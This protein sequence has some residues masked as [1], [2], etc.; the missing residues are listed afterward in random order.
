VAV[1]AFQGLILRTITVLF[2]YEG[3]GDC[4]STGVHVLVGTPTRKVYIPVVKLQL[5]VSSRVREI[6]ANDNS[7][8]VSV[9]CDCGNV[10]QLATI[11]LNAGQED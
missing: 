7:A 2:V 4:A 5:H 3:S 9:R 11:I 6:P 10:Q 8:G 1:P